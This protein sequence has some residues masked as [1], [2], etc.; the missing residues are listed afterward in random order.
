MFFKKKLKEI[1]ECEFLSFGLVI[2]WLK[3]IIYRYCLGNE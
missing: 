2:L 1:K 3:N